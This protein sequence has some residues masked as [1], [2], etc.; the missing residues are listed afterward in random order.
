MH[1]T[2][3]IIVTRI[4]ADNKIQVYPNPTQERVTVSSP[5][6]I[7]ST[8]LTDMPGR[9][10]EV[11]LTDMGDGQYTLNLTTRPQ[12]IFL[13]SLITTDGHRHTIRLLKQSRYN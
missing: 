10:K 5:V 6:R 2:K 4:A 1:I 13:L 8:T 12:A 9:R 11:R 3:C 7:N